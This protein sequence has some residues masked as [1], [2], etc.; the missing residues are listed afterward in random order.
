MVSLPLGCESHPVPVVLSEGGFQI[1]V[2][3]YFAIEFPRPT[4]TILGL[5]R[6]GRLKGGKGGEGVQASSD[7]YL[8]DQ[9]K[10]VNCML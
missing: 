5:L 4:N 7:L 1:L 8:E 9:A 3:Q 2:C 10:C 6:D